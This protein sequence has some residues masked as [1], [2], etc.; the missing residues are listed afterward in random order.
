MSLLESDGKRR[1]SVLGGQALVCSGR[2]QEPDHV[3]VILLRRH[4]EWREPV[5]RL[6]INSTP[7]LHQDFDNLMLQQRKEENEVRTNKIY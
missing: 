1:E 4:V 2:Q 5:L 7:V 3:V 6:D